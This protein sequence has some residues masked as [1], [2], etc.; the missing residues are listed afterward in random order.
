[1]TMAFRIAR[2]G[3][4]SALLIVL[5]GC[6]A[7]SATKPTPTPASASPIVNDSSTPLPTTTPSAS[8]SATPTPSVL[9]PLF[10]PSL[11]A[12]QMVGPRL[13][14]AVGSHAIFTT[15]D[16]PHCTKQYTPPGEFVRGR[17]LSPTTRCASPTTT[18]P[19]TPAAR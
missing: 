11:G 10:V 3:A 17:F 14:W 9:D 7:A 19:R 13:G 1:M 16:G 8:A 5:A 15:L 6:T 12:I 2:L 4:A 18:L